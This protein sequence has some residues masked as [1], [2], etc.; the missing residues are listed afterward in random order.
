MSTRALSKPN[1]SRYLLLGGFIVL[2][3]LLGAGLRLNPREV[4]SPLID[5]PAPDFELPQLQAPERTFSPAELRGRVWLLNVWASW[6]TSCRQE[7]PVLMD[8]ARS[9][10]LPILGLNYKDSRNAGIEWLERFGDPYQ[11]SAF[12]SKGA[13]G[14]DYG[15]YGVPETYLID[16]RG[17]IRYK[18]I[19]ILTPDIVQKTVLPLAQKLA[20]DG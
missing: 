17:T 9:G 6:C 1:L 7:H 10:R 20:R 2:V 13:V 12:D 11:L 15:V 14:I 5:K 18:H 3:A 4:P 8:L 19:G 16:Q